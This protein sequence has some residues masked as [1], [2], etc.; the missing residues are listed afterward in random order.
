MSDTRT[1]ISAIHAND[2]VWI[3][4]LWLAI[5]GGDPAPFL[6]PAALDKA[7]IGAIRALATQLDP[8]KQRAV[9]AALAH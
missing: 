4:Q 7:A 6:T 5:H 9:T 1:R 3:I 8:T 2:P